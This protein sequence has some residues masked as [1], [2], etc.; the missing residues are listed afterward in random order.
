M[1]RKHLIA[2]AKA[3]YY[4]PRGRLACERVFVEMAVLL[5]AG[6]GLGSMVGLWSSEVLL[7]WM[8]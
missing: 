2:P 7:G 1:L 5:W 6:W 4:K 8:Y 3:N